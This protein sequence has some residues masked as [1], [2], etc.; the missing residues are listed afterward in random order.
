MLRCPV[1][2]LGSKNEQPRR[3][4]IDQFNFQG[5]KGVLAIPVEGC[6][7]QEDSLN[8]TMLTIYYILGIL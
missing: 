3:R 1:N 6:P 2:D 4:G 8:K 7:V 5:L